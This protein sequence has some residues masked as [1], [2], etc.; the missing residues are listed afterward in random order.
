MTSKLTLSIDSE[1]IKKAKRLLQ[2]DNQ[3]LSG[4]VQDYFNVLIKTKEKFT[5]STPIVKELKGIAKGLNKSKDR[6]I[7]E[8]LEEKYK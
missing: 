7:F 5:T 6:A 4:L 1:T 3:S 2:K 8:Y